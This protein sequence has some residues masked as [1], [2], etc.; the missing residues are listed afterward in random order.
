MISNWNVWYQQTV[1]EH[2]PIMDCFIQKGL[3]PCPNGLPDGEK[4]KM[5]SKIN[6][7]SPRLTL[8][9]KIMIRAYNS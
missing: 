3:I 5:E 1:L 7:G 6:V 2:R 8:S 9:S 4:D